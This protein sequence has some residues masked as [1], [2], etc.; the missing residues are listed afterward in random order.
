MDFE[1]NF[2]TE[3]DNLNDAQKK[4][5]NQIDGPVMVV[6]GP[7]TGKTQ[8]LS[9]RVGNILRQTDAL[10]QNI[11]CLTFTDNA[12]NNMTKR[13]SE[14][15]GKEAYRVAVFTFHAF[16]QS[17]INQ[18][19]EFFFDGAGEA[20]E[21][22]DEITRQKIIG[23]ILRELPMNNPLGKLLDDEPIYLRGVVSAISD[24]KRAGLWHEDLAKILAENDNFINEVEPILAQFFNTPTARSHVEVA[25]YQA[26]FAA[27][28]L[29]NAQTDYQPSLANTL[30]TEIQKMIE[31]NAAHATP[32]TKFITEFR[33]TYL[34]KNRHGKWIMR[35]RK[36]G[37]KM[38]AAVE[39]YA[40][41]LAV[42]GKRRLYDFDDMI[43]RLVSALEIFPELKFNL[44]EQYQY[45]LV[46][47]LQDT[48][49]AQM[50]ILE[51][52]TDYSNTPNV[53]TVGDYKQAI[54]RFQGAEVANIAKFAKR[55][56]DELK[57][58]EL[59]NNYRSSS[60]ILDA[61]YAAIDTNSALRLD[62]KLTGKLTAKKDRSNAVVKH[63]VA[64]DWT[65]ELAYVA[66]NIER[67]IKAGIA[68]ENIAVIAKK[69][70]HLAEL[71]PFLATKNI[72]LQYEKEQD[73]L[74]SPPVKQLEL[75]ARATVHIA[76]QDFDQANELLPKIL[77]HP[78]WDITTIELWKL[79]LAAAH[80]NWLDVMLERDGNIKT[81]AEKILELAR[82]SETENLGTML[83]AA[84]APYREHFFN[85]KNRQKNPDEYLR[86]LSDLTALRNLVRDYKGK[87]DLELADFIELI[88]AYRNLGETI[89][90]TRRYQTGNRVQLL[91]AH[92]A[93]G[94]EFDT[95]YILNATNDTWAKSMR[96][97]NSLV[98]PSNIPLSIDDSEDEHARLLYVAMT[99]A[100]RQLFITTHQFDDKGRELLPCSYL[101]DANM[102]Q[103]KLAAE[104]IEKQVKNTETAWHK[105][106]VETTPT[107]KDL[108]APMLE[109]Y[110]IS[111]TH[112]NRFTDLEYG[113][114]EV[115]LMKTLLRF[116]E[117]KSAN[118]GFGTAIHAT[119]QFVHNALRADEKMPNSETIQ[120]YFTTILKKQSLSKLD[121][122]KYLK[123]GLSDLEVFVSQFKFEPAQ[124]AERKF[125]QDNVVVDEMRLN[126]T[127]DMLIVDKERK[128]IVVYDYKTGQAYEKWDKTTKLHKYRQQLL[129]YKILVENSREFA[130]YTVTR[131]VLQ[132]VEPLD[133]EIVSLDLDYTE[134][135]LN[136]H[137]KL[138]RAVW[139]R[140]INLDLPNTSKYSP[141][142]KG[143]L[144][145]E[146][147][148][149]G[150]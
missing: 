61:A 79:A 127:I 50:K 15:F 72:P 136:N 111:P 90:L 13:M 18:Y 41:Y 54:F 129:F 97:R 123:K 104:S 74:A 49:D 62:A 38:K 100:E 1:K 3:Y 68:P 125:S 29:P 60:K 30:K 110:K 112:L 42:M 113:G 141:D 103:E 75:L 11:L 135:E 86:Y 116:P 70:R 25:R 142:L 78:A 66:D 144:Q 146:K 147:D 134:E 95:V 63:V 77:A 27:L 46:D 71:V 73:V 88:D 23:D 10:A 119:L 65:S 64:T 124:I 126:G 6:A 99:R 140:I 117:A 31:L 8:L 22:A 24:I 108:L 131:G 85:E 87:D 89:T 76:Q 67:Q 12:S 106:L 56:G 47:E 143:T 148:L 133:G 59:E 107:L 102:A 4:A 53:M 16:A 28:K 109:N 80:K 120:K 35:D 94:L 139:H 40:K 26:K 14:L 138:L 2:Q 20:F 118:A 150:E 98:F 91:S 137:K 130:G 122:Q 92:K 93:K 5:V 52:L 21:A 81:A 19:P 17:V 34:E 128:E 57:L 43:L 96:G 82:N 105:S 132:F 145:F 48:N 7:G 149:I 115:F 101:A 121:Y 32:T 69:H 39:V 58:F 44:Q 114:P 51:F 9:M 45:I 36:R 83:D 33:N 84:F 37:K 55:F